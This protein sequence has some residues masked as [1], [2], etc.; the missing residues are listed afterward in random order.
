MK[1]GVNRMSERDNSLPMVVEDSLELFDKVVALCN[2]SEFHCK[3]YREFMRGYLE[4]NQLNITLAEMG[5]EEDI[6]DLMG[7]ESSLEHEKP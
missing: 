7:Y 4:V 3:K 1:G 2:H 6:S 5:L